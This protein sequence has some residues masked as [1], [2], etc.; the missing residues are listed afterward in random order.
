[1][2]V[3][4][5]RALF[6]LALPVAERMYWTHVAARVEGDVYFPAVDWSQWEL[7]AEEPHAA[8][9]ANDYAFALREYVRRDAR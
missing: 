8:D 4:G 2:F 9:D 6:E 3:I 1:M 7:I 5:G